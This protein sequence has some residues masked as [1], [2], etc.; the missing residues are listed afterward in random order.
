M[1]ET[2][3]SSGVL[4]ESVILNGAIAN[5]FL[6]PFF[7]RWVLPTRNGNRHRNDAVSAPWKKH[8]WSMDWSSN[9]FLQKC[10][11][12]WSCPTHPSRD[13]LWFWAHGAR[14]W[15]CCHLS[16]TCNRDLSVKVNGKE[17][18]W[19]SRKEN[20][21]A[22]P[23]PGLHAVLGAKASFWKQEKFLSKSQLGPLM[24]MSSPSKTHIFLAKIAFKKNTRII[25]SFKLVSPGCREPTNQTAAMFDSTS[26]KAAP[27]ASNKPQNSKAPKDHCMLQHFYMFKALKYIVY[28]YTLLILYIFPFPTN[29]FQSSFHA[30]ST[31]L[32]GHGGS[33][34]HHFIELLKL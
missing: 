33:Y 26:L 6:H 17:S 2:H 13:H 10:F 14:F 32:T 15:T 25:A 34:V 27:M 7:I 22:N 9:F 18:R 24:S 4:H 29:L 28:I 31:W 20:L 1:I 19:A 3:V 5:V 30:G 12:R 11:R 23:P 8:I 21:Q 16:Q